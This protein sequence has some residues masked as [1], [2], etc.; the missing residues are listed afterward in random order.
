VRTN[1]LDSWQS[2]KIPP[3]HKRALRMLAASQE[4]S[5]SAVLREAVEIVVDGM[6]EPV[7]AHPNPFVAK[8]QARQTGSTRRIISRANS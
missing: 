3:E 1:D 5:V 2:F 8:D 6:A 4:R 7:E